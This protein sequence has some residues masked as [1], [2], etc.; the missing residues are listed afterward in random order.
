MKNICMW[1]GKDHFLSEYALWARMSFFDTVFPRPKFVHVIRN[2]KAVAYE[3]K[4]MIKKGVYP[5]SEEIEWWTSGWPEE[6]KEEFE[7]KYG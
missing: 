1:Q 6:W 7:E 4:K 2:G 3:Y 5:E